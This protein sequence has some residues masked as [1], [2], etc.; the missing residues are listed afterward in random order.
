[1]ASRI[2][3][4]APWVD[5]RPG[6]P[7]SMSTH[8]RET[9]KLF[10]KSRSE[11]HTLYIEQANKNKRL[12]MILAFIL[13]IASTLI[14][15]FAPEGRETLSYWIGGAL[16]IFSAGAL[17]YGRVWGKASA[18]SFGADQDDRPL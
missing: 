9:A 10:I 6:P 3:L 4:S 2:K 5:R 8:D 14:L 15:V 18:I 1:M 11:V 17:G 12:G 7:Q 16:I 13:I